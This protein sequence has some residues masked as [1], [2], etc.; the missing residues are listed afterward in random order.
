MLLRLLLLAL[1][2]D[3]ADGVAADAAPTWHA[4][5]APLVQEHCGSCHVAGGVAPFALDDYGAAAPMAASI[6]AA[7]DAGTMPPWGAESTDECAPRFGF[8]DDMRLTD[9]EKALLRAWADAGAPEG[10][11]AT[12]A[13]LP[14]R[15]ELD[16]VNPSIQVAPPLDYVTSGSTDQFRC[17]SVDPQLTEDAWLT[18]LQV[19]PGNAEV[20]HHVLVFADP[21]G[22]SATLVGADGT[23]DCFGGSG[24]SEGGALVG[25]WAPGAFP[26]EAPPGS[27][28]ALEAGSLLV[29]QIHYHPLGQVAAPD[30]TTLQLR[31]ADTRPD[32]EAVLALVGNASSGAEGLE[33]GPND[34]TARAEFRIPAGVPDHTESI[35]YTLPASDGPYPIFMAGTHMHYVGTDMLIEVDHAAPRGD[36]PATECLVQTPRWDFDWQRGYT[37]DAPLDEVPV[38]R[39]GDT[40]RMRCTY[41]NTLDN[42]GVRVA[43]EDA[44]LT[45]PT[46]VYLGEA[47]IDEMCLGVFGIV[48]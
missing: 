34:R 33:A 4:D 17:F 35:R 48:I 36:E 16:L 14:P 47:T 10:D 20:V 3:G 46:D 39:G 31:W 44:G 45:E 23:Y 12:A 24:L 5:I 38:L 32:H 22:Q 19:V 13:E 28:I 41:D 26:F 9:D 21:A 42:P 8:V 1:G 6:V 37:Y 18:G 11:A 29:M 25:A 7:V 2:C 15:V 43:L 40:L 27:G 30:S